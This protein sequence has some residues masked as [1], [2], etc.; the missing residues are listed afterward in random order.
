MSEPKVTTEEML[1]KL[2]L[3]FELHEDPTFSGDSSINRWRQIH[4]AIRRRIKGPKVTREF[5]ERWAKNLLKYFFGEADDSGKE[6]VISKLE[7][8]FK[9]MGINEGIPIFNE[10]GH[11][12]EEE[13]YSRDTGEPD[14]REK[15]H[16]TEEEK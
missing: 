1:E 13:G 11:S 15:G 3:A 12:N 4:Q 9:E 8:M 6:V 14:I 5:V 10:G 7:E 2:D 16:N